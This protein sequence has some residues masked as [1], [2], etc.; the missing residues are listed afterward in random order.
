MNGR[1]GHPWA[2]LQAHAKTWGSAALWGVLYLVSGD[3]AI[4]GIVG[5]G[6]PFIAFVLFPRQ[7]G[8]L[9]P[10]LAWVHWFE[11][12]DKAPSM[13]ELLERLRGRR[14]EEK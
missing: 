1:P 2:S 12:Y 11:R 14:H 13:S 7:I 5:L 8:D 3:A 9:H 6:V 10:R 4:S